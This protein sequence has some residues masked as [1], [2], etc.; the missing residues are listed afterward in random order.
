M[1]R[2]AV[3]PQRIYSNHFQFSL[4]YYHRVSRVVIVLF[5]TVLRKTRSTSEWNE[6][7]EHLPYKL[8]VGTG[9]SYFSAM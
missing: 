9:S 6:Q 4:F 5:C 8:N 2:A 7:Y 1:H 3:R